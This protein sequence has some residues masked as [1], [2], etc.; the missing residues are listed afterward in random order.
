[1]LALVLALSVPQSLEEVERAR[2][3]ELEKLR[4]ARPADPGDSPAFQAWDAKVFDAQWEYGLAL[5]RFA[6]MRKTRELWAR[7][8]QFWTD[9][10]WEREDYLAALE[11]RLHVA[12]AQQALQNWGPVFANLK[13]ARLTDTPERRRNPDLADL[14]TRALILEARARLA[15]GRDHEISLKAARAHLVQFPADGPALLQLRLETARL[16]HAAHYD[17]ESRRVLEELLAKHPR[18]DAGDEALVLLADLFQRR[19]DAC[20]DRLFDAHRYEDAAVRYRRLPRSPRV[21]L[22][23]GQ[24]Y[25]RSRRFFEAV[26]VLSRACAVDSPHRV[27]AAL[28]LE[29]VLGHLVARLGQAALKPR[30]DAH[31]AWMVSTFGDAI[32]PRLLLL[33]G[34]ALAREKKFREAADVYGRVAAGVEGHEEAVH[35]RAYCFYRLQEFAPALDL[36]RRYLAFEK[37]AS[38]ST[39]SAID[40]AAWC[41]AKLDRPAELLDHVDRHAPADPARGQW[42]L[43]HR[44]DA[45][46]RLGRF[47]EARETLG[48]MKEDVALDPTVRA[49]ERLAVG[50]EAVVRRKNDPK[51][52]A[53]YARTVLALSEKS[54]KPLRGDKLL[55]AADAIYLEGTAEA[56]ALAFDLYSQYLPAAKLRDEEARPIEYRRATA[57]AGAG[58]LERA[59]QIADALTAAEPYNG[60]YQELRADILGLQADALPRSPERRTLV[61]RAMA[62]YGELSAAMRGKDVEPWYRL[63]WKYAARL[64]EVDPDRAKRFFLL[65]EKRGYGPWDENRWGYKAKMEEL[66]KQVL[67]P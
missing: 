40:L 28:E 55:S 9:F 49:L 33:Q 6:E 60:T 3:A 25:A 7:V 17:L 31:R 22:R 50:Y 54:F 47:D 15:Q 14:A 63:T 30:L 39:D 35:A 62:T 43:A 34:D 32:G 42:R 11:A 10:I 29:K 21:E 64:V 46:A 66:R 19:V 61:E 27:D 48:T 38:A 56:Y 16:L 59:L 8:V 67:T 18:T 24:S 45:L 57:A 41:L 51:L 13:A 65:M 20:A 36:F 23:L 37:R 44:V 2:H 26:D 5:T 4:Q 53:A 58:K 52:W 1:M 12:R